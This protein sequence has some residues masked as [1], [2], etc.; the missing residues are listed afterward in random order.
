MSEGRAQRAAQTGA[1]ATVTTHCGET[2]D[3]YVGTRF[4]FDCGLVDVLLDGVAARTAAPARPSITGR[5]THD[6]HLDGPAS[7]RVH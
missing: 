6:P 5:L 4:D 7:R 2:H 3:I 1:T